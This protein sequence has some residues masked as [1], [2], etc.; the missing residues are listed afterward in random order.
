MRKS[1]RFASLKNEIEEARKIKIENI[2]KAYNRYYD[3]EVD[4]FKV[5]LNNKIKAF[6]ISE[7]KRL[8]REMIKEKA[9][10][11][12]LIRS[13]VIDHRQTWIE[14]L[15]AELEEKIIEFAKSNDYSKWLVAKVES[16]IA[17]GFDVGTIQANSHDLSILKSI[18]K[19]NN[20]LSEK[21][22]MIG[23][24]II[25][26]KANNEAINSTFEDL[27]QEQKQYFLETYKLLINTEGDK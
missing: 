3:K 15:F 20:L 17:D 13:A 23:G 5:D 11:E 4:T 22:E 26:N 19:K 21:K 10:Q 25:I 12:Y 27:I 1:E 7:E 8:E 18:I 16:V 14:K 6:L 2:E 24:F 9:N